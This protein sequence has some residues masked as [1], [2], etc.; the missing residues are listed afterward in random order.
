VFDGILPAPGGKLCVLAVAYPRSEFGLSNNDP[1]ELVSLDLND[2]SIAKLADGMAF[3]FAGAL[4]PDGRQ[5]AIAQGKVTLVYELASRKLI[6]T[7]PSAFEVAPLRWGPDG[8][9]LQH[10]NLGLGEAAVTLY[11]W[12]PGQGEPQK[13]PG[14]LSSPDGRYHLEATKEGLTIN[15][16]GGTR[17]V[18]PTHPEDAEAFDPLRPE[19]DARWLGPQ[20]LLV[21]LEEPMALDLST[22]KLHYLFPA[23]GMKV[24]A[25]SPDGRIVIARD[26][27]GDS[28]WAERR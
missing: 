4:S 3:G 5:V 23:A 9:V 28:Y 20:Y 15:G 24:Q 8:L 27:R 11:V 25:S 14:P 13:I 6:A 18:T 26:D 16:P 21:T 19:D 17:K 2:G 22:G 12:Q 1:A 7:T 10:Q